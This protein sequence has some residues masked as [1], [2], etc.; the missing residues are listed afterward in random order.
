MRLYGNILLTCVLR[1]RFSCK[2]Y[3]RGTGQEAVAAFYEHGDEL[4]DF[5]KDSA[6]WSYLFSCLNL[7]VASVALF[8]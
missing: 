8:L 4:L 5:K 3:S 7:Y 1:N 2:L 6:L